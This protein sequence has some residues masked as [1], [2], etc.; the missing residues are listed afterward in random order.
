M[1]GKEQDRRK[2]EDNKEREKKRR[3]DGQRDEKK[4][5]GS[6]NESGAYTHT[7]ILQGLPL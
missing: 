7:R 1:R 4:K 3:S 6:K 2:N 5:Q